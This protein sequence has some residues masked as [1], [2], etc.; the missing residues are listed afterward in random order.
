[1]N[2]QRDFTGTI[3]ESTDVKDVLKILDLIPETV[4]TEEVAESDY[5]IDASIAEEMQEKAEAREL[6]AARAREQALEDDF[7]EAKSNLRSL[8]ERQKEVLDDLIALAKA[9]DSPRAYEVVATMLKTFSDL[10]MSIL[11]LHGKKADIDKKTNAPAQQAG[12]IN[13][14]QNNF[15]GTTKEINA[16]LREQGFSV[17]PHS[18]TENSDE[19]SQS[20]SE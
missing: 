20:H 19:R 18:E 15:T 3:F 13:N 9:S 2:E 4:T 12:V 5:T 6:V 1:M 14:V 10:E 11:D 16:L 7:K 17:A 8:A